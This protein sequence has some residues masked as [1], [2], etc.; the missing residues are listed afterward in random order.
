MGSE[1]FTTA[2]RK[3]TGMR[4]A[5]LAEV[6]EAQDEYGHESYNGTISTTSGVFQAVH[7]PMTATGAN[8]YPY[9]DETPRKWQA[10]HAIP[11]A[12][13]GDFRTHTV[14]F[15]VELPPVTK[16]EWGT[17]V[18]VTEWQLREAAIKK[19][20][21]DWGHR[22]HDVK[23]NVKLKTKITAEPTPGTSVRRYQVVG[24]TGFH[25]K[26][27]LYDTKA[28]AVKAAKEA[29]G[30]SIIAGTVHVET[31]QYWPAPDTTHAVTV[32][33]TTV[34][35]AADVVVTINTVKTHEPK[36]I[37]WVFYGVAAC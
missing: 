10:A 18:N 17:E 27:K 14:K 34:A 36:I 28:Q 9:F 37:G 32:K 3:G 13:D 31:V 26:P 23:V 25:G 5:Y 24:T 4:E 20:F 30:K 35:A 15:T 2:V 7:Q 8:L 12:D 29:L 11:I 33:K 6:R 16:T 19:A 21:Q 1:S 22:V